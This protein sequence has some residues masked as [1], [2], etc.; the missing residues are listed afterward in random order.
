MRRSTVQLFKIDLNNATKRC[1]DCA[2]AGPYQ[3]TFRSDDGKRLE[4]GAK[5][6][7]NRTV[8]TIIPTELIIDMLVVFEHL[9]HE[10]I[11]CQEGKTWVYLLEPGCSLWQPRGSGSG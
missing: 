4:A 8:D 5:L 10:R 2:H 7:L 1:A 11:L 9:Y 3:I 6:M